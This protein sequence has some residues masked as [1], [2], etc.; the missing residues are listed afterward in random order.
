MAL[1]RLAKSTLSVP[2]VF[3]F[4]QSVV[5]APAC[6]RRFLDHFAQPQPGDRLLDLGCGTG[7]TL[8]HLPATVSYVGVDISQDYIDA[9]RARFQN[10][11]TFLCSDVAS[12]DLARF[13]PFDLAISFGVLHHLDE[14][15]ARAMVA[16]AQR[17]LRPGGHLVTIDPCRLP[18]QPW[19]ARFLIE[20]DRGRHVRNIEQYRRLF[21]SC[22]SVDT[23]VLSDMLRIPSSMIVA[24]AWV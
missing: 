6:H 14:P 24:R 1:F 21:A 23:D 7:A 8:E 19:T 12:V 13:A 15:S 22:A 11:G 4:F 5:G 20:H 10:R 18:S 3:G 17:M 16:L 2:S 9:A